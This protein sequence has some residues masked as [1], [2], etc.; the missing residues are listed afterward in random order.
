MNKLFFALSIL[1]C[2][3]FEANAQKLWGDAVFGMTPSQVA[4]VYPQATPARGTVDLSDRLLQMN[5]I[6]LGEVHSTVHF[7]FREQKLFGV[8]WILKPGKPFEATQSIY[9]TLLDG[10]KR[11]HPQELFIAHRRSLELSAAERAKTA[12]WFVDRLDQQARSMSDEWSTKEGTKVSMRMEELVRGKSAHLNVSTSNEMAWRR[13]RAE[14]EAVEQEKRLAN[15]RTEKEADE[16]R[17]SEFFNGFVGKNINA[18]A[19][20]A[21]APTSTTSMPKG[22]VIYVWETSSGEGLSCRTS[23]FTRKKGLIYNWQWSGN[24]C[25]RKQER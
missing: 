11:E 10:M 25:R 7:L 8:D 5:F 24:S 2:V 18:L 14:A 20:S 16:R 15:I 22:E 21:G 9:E 19:A 1:W 4:E 12:T 13:F 6:A 3:S 17:H 23:V